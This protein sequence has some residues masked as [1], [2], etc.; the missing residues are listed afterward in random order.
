[1]PEVETEFKDDV[2]T[3]MLSNPVLLYNYLFKDSI[4]YLHHT[5]KV[6]QQELAQARIAN[7]A[8]LVLFSV[9]TVSEMMAFVV[10]F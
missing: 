4:I 7:N 6:K 5:T 3:D 1:M 10:V 9:I 8:P 2:N